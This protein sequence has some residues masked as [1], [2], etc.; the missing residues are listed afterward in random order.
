MLFI[1]FF[2]G[3]IDLPTIGGATAEQEETS[4]GK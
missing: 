1:A 3:K 4:D 2:A